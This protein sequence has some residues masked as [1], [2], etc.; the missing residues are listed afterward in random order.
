MR[1]YSDHIQSAVVSITVF[2]HFLM[3]W[4]WKTLPP[5]KIQ[6]QRRLST[7]TMWNT[8]H[9]KLP[10]PSLYTLFFI[11]SILWW[12]HKLYISENNL[13]KIHLKFQILT[14]YNLV[15]QDVFCASSYI[16]QTET[17]VMI[18]WPS[19]YSIIWQSSDFFH[20]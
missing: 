8:Y 9:S 13:C 15:S 5:V 2:Q 3:L 19:G 10:N 14:E 20:F 17:A 18:I 12:Q 4:Y 6:G 11:L 7:K 16:L 1:S